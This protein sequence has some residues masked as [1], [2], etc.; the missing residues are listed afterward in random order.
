MER[1]KTGIPGFDELISGGIPKNRT[2]LVSGHCG[3]GKTMFASQFIHQ[4]LKKDESAVYVTFEQGR[5]KLFQDSKTIGIDLEHYEKKNKVKIIGGPVGKIKRFKLKTEANISDLIEEIREVIEETKAKRVAIDS[6][7]LFAMLFGDE[8]EKRNAVAM[9]ISTLEEADCTSI[10]TCE[11]PE[12]SDQISWYGFE[13]FVVDG[14]VF[15]HRSNNRGS[16]ERAISVIKMRGTSHEQKIKAMQ[17][18]DKGLV[19]YDQEPDF[20][21]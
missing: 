20:T 18:K 11:V 21:R 3:S 8:N 19:I 4:G 16:Y 14:V 9:L 10:L 7:N 12:S 6:V 2:I 1:V 15:L 5:E 17:I 13:D